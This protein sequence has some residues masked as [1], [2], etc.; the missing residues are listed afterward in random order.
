M[1]SLI[2]TFKALT[3]ETRLRILNLLLEKECC[4]CEVM[5]ALDISQTRSSRNLNILYDAGF[6]KMRKDG[7]WSLYS[8]D[9]EKL[10]GYFPYL[11]DAVR[12]G[13][14]GNETTALDRERLSKAERVGPH[15]VKKISC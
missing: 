12:N 15:C 9:E 3:D 1:H 6:L 5:Q 7:L 11:I 13:L 4:V 14:E 10:E 2:K 8:I